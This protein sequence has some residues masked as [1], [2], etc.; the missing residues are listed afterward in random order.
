MKFLV[1]MPL[2]PGLFRW[3]GERGHDAVHAANLGLERAPDTTILERAELS[4]ALF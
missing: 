4:S 2:S 3:L 1:D